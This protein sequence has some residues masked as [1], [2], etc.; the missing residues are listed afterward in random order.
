MR[1]IDAV[2]DGN[3]RHRDVDRRFLE[4]PRLIEIGSAVVPG[5]HRADAA[6]E[7]E[8]NHQRADPSGQRRAHALAN[9][10]QN[11]KASKRRERG[12]EK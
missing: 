7:A 3:P 2:A 6:R 8:R 5:D 12:K 1:L 11:H 9:E 10:K 4:S